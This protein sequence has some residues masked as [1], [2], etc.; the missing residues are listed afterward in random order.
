[1]KKQ[2][3]FEATAFEDFSNWATQNKKVY[4]KIIALIK[5]IQRSP[6]RGLGKPELLK[7]ELRGFW[8]RRINQEHRLVYKVTDSAIIIA[9]CKYHY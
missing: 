1:M 6:V 5:D 3:I 2:I 7:H 9:A 8:S 4:K